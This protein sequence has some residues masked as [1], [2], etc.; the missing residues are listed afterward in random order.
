MPFHFHVLTLFMLNPQPFSIIDVVQHPIFE[1]YMS[2]SSRQWRHLSIWSNIKSSPSLKLII[3]TLQPPAQKGSYFDWGMCDNW[4]PVTHIIPPLNV[5]SYAQFIGKFT[6]LH[7]FVTDSL[8]LRSL[9]LAPYYL[10]YI[11]WFELISG[12]WNCLLKI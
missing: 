6:K 9:S 4:L 5:C 7:C 8:L 2:I 11:S 3:Y 1:I 12:C 10:Y